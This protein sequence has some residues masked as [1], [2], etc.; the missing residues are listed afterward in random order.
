MCFDLV[1]ARS[2]FARTVEP[3][4]LSFVVRRPP[5]TLLAVA[6]ADDDVLPAFASIYLA[7][8][9][10]YQLTPFIMSGHVPNAST[11][12]YYYY[13]MPFHVDDHSQ[14]EEDRIKD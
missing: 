10:R 13:P 14:N 8:A 6:V 4:H 1:V 2:S 5:L 3:L 12:V 9:L 11:Y 7:Y